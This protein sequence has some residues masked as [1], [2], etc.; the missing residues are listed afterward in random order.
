MN[1]NLLPPQWPIITQKRAFIGSLIFFPVFFLVVII[2]N[3]FD[4]DTSNEHDIYAIFLLAIPIVIFFLSI[5]SLRVYSSSTQFGF[6][7]SS[8]LVWALAIN[9]ILLSFLIWVYKKSW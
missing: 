1:K 7:Y 6:N 9:V 3:G 5:W 8:V 4:F 2:I